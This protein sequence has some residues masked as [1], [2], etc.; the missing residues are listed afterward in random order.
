MP[1]DSFWIRNTWSFSHWFCSISLSELFSIHAFF[2]FTFQLMSKYRHGQQFQRVLYPIEA[3]WN[4]QQQKEKLFT[5]I[6]I[7]QLNSQCELCQTKLGSASDFT[8]LISSSALFFSA[9]FIFFNLHL[10]KIAS[11]LLRVELIA[12]AVNKMLLK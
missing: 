6:C 1:W 9:V 11:R 12:A 7:S 2:L 3:E 4:W 10:K 8:Y 5:L